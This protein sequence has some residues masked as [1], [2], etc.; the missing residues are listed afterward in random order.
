MSYVNFFFIHANIWKNFRQHKIF[1]YTTSITYTSYFHYLHSFRS[2]NNSFLF[3]RYQSHHIRVCQRD[4]KAHKQSVTIMV[5][6]H[7]VLLLFFDFNDKYI[8]AGQSMYTLS[9][10]P[11]KSYCN[12]SDEY[13]SLVTHH[14][15]L[16]DLI[17]IQNSQN[18]LR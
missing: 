8:I 16:L 3:K 17:F 14:H 18:L 2:L 1:V 6:I 7:N 5:V 15:C 11:D 10:P 13:V 4:N 12:C 9:N